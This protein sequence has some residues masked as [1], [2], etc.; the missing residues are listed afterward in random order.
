[1][2]VTADGRTER[3]VY[4]HPLAGDTVAA[5]AEMSE[6][7][8]Q[9]HLLTLLRRSVSKRMMSDVPF[10]VSSPAALTLPRT[11]SM[12]ELV[13]EPVRNF[14]TAPRGHPKY[15]ELA[16]ARVVARRFGTDHHEVVLDESRP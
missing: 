7:E 14:S 15:D 3:D 6:A 2:T 9:T 10:G 16:P 8:M 13:E 12:S 11:P 1:M 5:V 4:W